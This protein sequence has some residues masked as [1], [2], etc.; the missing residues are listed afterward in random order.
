[1]IIHRLSK[2]LNVPKHLRNPRKATFGSLRNLPWKKASSQQL[3]TGN[4]ISTKVYVNRSHQ[5]L[6]GSFPEPREERQLEKQ[7]KEDGSHVPTGPRHHDIEAHY[8]CLRT[9]MPSL[10]S[11]HKKQPT[12]TS[13]LLKECHIIFKI[14]TYS[15]LLLLSTPRATT[16]QILQRHP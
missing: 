2:R 7:G 10:R 14:Q 11:N 8:L 15:R 9:Q 12:R 6:N 4:I 3:G 5:H 16:A 1:M 13:L